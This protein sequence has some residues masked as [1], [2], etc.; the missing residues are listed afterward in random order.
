MYATEAQAALLRAAV[1][2]DVSVTIQ[3]IPANAPDLLAY[4]RLDNANLLAAIRLRPD[5]RL[6]VLQPFGWHIDGSHIPNAAEHFEREWICEEHGWIVV[7]E[8][9]P[10]IAIVRPVEPG[11]E[12]AGSIPVLPHVV[13][14]QQEDQ[15][16]TREELK[17]AAIECL[18]KAFTGDASIG[19]HVVQAAVAIVLTP[20]P[21]S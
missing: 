6:L 9:G 18:G 10:Y 1:A 15:F 21:Q 4:E 12:A 8:L 14:S 7:D 19:A 3:R 13:S 17:R 5:E 2:G 20:D 11:S 16:V